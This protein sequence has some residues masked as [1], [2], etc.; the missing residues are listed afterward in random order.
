MNQESTP[1]P[2]RGALGAIFLTVV[3]DL[4]GFGIILPV[5]PLYVRCFGQ[6]ELMVGVLFAAYSGMQFFFAPIWG[7]IS[8]R[9]GRRPVLLIS[10]AGNCGAL[11]VFGLAEDYWWL[12]AA[13]LVAGIATANISTAYA[14]IA[15]ISPP[16]LRAK[17]MGLVGAAFGI[18]FVLGPF[19]GGESAS[20]GLSMPPFVA[21]ALAAINFVMA[22]L[23][24]PE[25]LPPENR[26]KH[27]PAKLRNRLAIVRE[28][29]GLGIILILVFVQVAAFSMLEVAH[30][31]FVNDR[32]GMPLPQTLAA[33]DASGIGAR[34]FSAVGRSFAFI[35]V[36]LAVVQGGLIGPL[37]RKFGEMRLVWT[38]LVLVG[39][40]MLVIPLT[41]SG[42]WAFLLV[43]LAAVAGGQALVTPSLSA[44]LSKSTPKQLQGSAQGASQSSSA[45]ARLIG[46]LIA[47][48]LYAYGGENVPYFVG[49]TLMLVA[50]FWAIRAL[51]RLSVTAEKKP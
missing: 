38:G 42:N 6:S 48:A 50:L 36:I 2:G 39:A 14:Y 37:V 18:G 26:T 28:V 9:I 45:L 25:S 8:D 17:R 34:Q 5:M 11:V 21:A 7:A 41:P 27:A 49:G 3:V 43:C 24:L 30:S 16:E 13:R 22:A 32:M 51:P 20:F 15:D 19:I 35:G 12:F 1:K 46:P 47:G 40:G 23:F 33:C 29:D 10:I 44:L 4:I 31:L